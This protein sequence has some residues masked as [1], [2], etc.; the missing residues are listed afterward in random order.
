MSA[1]FNS[2]AANENVAS[3]G[4]EVGVVRS[5]DDEKLTKKLVILHTLSI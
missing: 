1:R 4:G 2:V 3:R 5:R